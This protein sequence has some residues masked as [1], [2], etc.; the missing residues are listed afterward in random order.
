MARPKLIEDSILLDLIKKYFYEECHNNPKKLKAVQIV[1]YI[2]NNGFPDYP[3]TTLRR[4]K[5][6]MDY[7]EE[8]KKT[9]NDDNYVTVVSYQTIDAALL[10][11]SNRSRDRLI[12][13][14]SE[15]D[16]YYKTVADS[17]AQSFERYNKIKKQFD[18]EKEKN[19]LLTEKITELEELNAKYKS[20]IK[21]LTAELSASKS[22]IET[23]IY[24]EIANELLVKEGAVRKT[25]GFIKEEALESNL[26]TPIT[27]IK[28]TAKSGSSVIKGLFN[29]LEE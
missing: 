26:I 25:E 9:I 5:V 10:V 16:S 21:M 13:A 29:I 24:P 8:L 1:K 14:I 2:N 4:T 20:D 23:Y 3:I 19:V 12:K 6:A 17:A 22:V 7:I 27:N 15:R 18:T 28:N 11:E